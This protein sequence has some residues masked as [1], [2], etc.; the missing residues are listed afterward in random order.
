M[1]LAGYCL[2]SWRN[3]YSIRSPVKQLTARQRRHMVEWHRAHGASIPATCAQFGVS[4]ATLYRWLA[5][6][7]ADP[8]KPLRSQSRRP[9]TRRGSAWA[10]AEVAKLC[11]LMID[12]PTWGR[13]RLT[14][15]LAAQTTTSRSPATV[16]RM[17]ARIRVR[18][19]ICG[20]RE[21]Y[22]ERGAHAL[23]QDLTQGGVSMPLRPAPPDPEKTALRREKAAAVREVQRLLRRR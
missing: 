18:C 14:V 9:H 2:F 15:A 7:A 1:I 23:D 10:R 4:R 5:H 19:P 6:H 12:H 11:A 8:Q 22:H 21:G 17:L 16:G 20:G 3:G 13:G